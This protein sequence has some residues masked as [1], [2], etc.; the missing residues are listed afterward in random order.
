MQS[1]SEPV[2]DFAAL[3][4]D[5]TVKERKRLLSQVQMIAADGASPASQADAEAHDSEG[6]RLD[7]VGFDTI[8]SKRTDW[9]WQDRVP[10]GMLSQLVGTEGLGKS[11]LTVALVAAVTRGTL[12]GDYIG[13][14]ADVVLLTTEDA[15]EYT[16]KPRLDAAGADCTRVKFVQ[17]SKDGDETGGVVLP[18]D[19]GRL[20]RVLGEAGVRLLVI[21]P[22]AGVLDPSVDTYKD[23]SVREAL[24]PLV[25]AAGEHDFAVL[26]VR[27]T[28]KGKSNDA[29]D[30]AMGSVGFRQIVRSS[31]LVTVD[32][33]G[34]DGKD[35]PARIVAH[36]KCNVGRHARSV[37][38]T[39]ETATVTI[40]GKPETTVKAVLG[41]EC[42]WRA[43][44]GLAAEE[45]VDRE[46]MATKQT[47][48]E[49]L[50]R[51]MTDNG[52]TP[53]AQAKIKAEAQSAGIGWRTVE[54]AKKR[55]GYDS[56]K[57]TGTNANVWG[58]QRPGLAV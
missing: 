36:E 35:G 40:E 46:K 56:W 54:E 57:P 32:P 19:A 20:G 42:D 38:F 6:Y 34:E 8:T 1:V 16:I 50:L 52:Q 2:R 5:T 11:A 47:D 4:A 33:D 49:A 58:V 10:R 25:A 37:R 45:G 24:A 30:R 3:L 28:N 41:E 55:V 15:P 26:G 9:L 43:S 29:R 23:S 13:K 22:L 44:D 27:H 48:A 17:L 18:R 7:L 12:P 39:T 21:D 53:C 14:P 31:L 51:R